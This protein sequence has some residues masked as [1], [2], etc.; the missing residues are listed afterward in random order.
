MF[1]YL[2][3]LFNQLVFQTKLTHVDISYFFYSRPDF[4]SLI[5]V[6]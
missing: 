3:F 6:V 4:L 2:E 5:K 1:L